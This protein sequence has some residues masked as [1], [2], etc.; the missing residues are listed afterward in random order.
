MKSY[1]KVAGE[2]MNRFAFVWDAL[3]VEDSDNP[4][5]LN[6]LYWMTCQVQADALSSET[7]CHRWLGYVQ[8][9]LVMKGLL[10]VEE[11]RNFTR[12]IFNGE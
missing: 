6:H 10:D 8:G 4:T 1:Q 12:K 11:E 2:Y 3:V 7:R 9:V 5:S